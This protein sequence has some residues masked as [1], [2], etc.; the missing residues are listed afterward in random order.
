[1]KFPD[2]LLIS[3]VERDT[4]AAVPNV[5]LVLILKALKNDYYV[6]PAITDEAGLC[7]FT[8]ADCEEAISIAQKM[9]VM[10]YS[11]SLLDC[12]PV[13]EVRLHTPEQIANMIRQFKSNPE[14]WGTPFNNPHEFFVRLEKAANKEFAAFQMAATEEEILSNP[15]LKIDLVRKDRD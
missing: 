5:A 15:E 9:F 10:D 14:F 6:G 2:A 4:Q 12:K 3:A 1:M 13:V 8:R 7:R 11:G